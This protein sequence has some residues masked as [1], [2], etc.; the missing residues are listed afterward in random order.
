MTEIQIKKLE[1]SEVEII[2]ELPEKDFAVYRKG[3]LEKI[4]KNIDVPG[5]RKGH[6]PENILIKR[7]PERAI[8]EEMAEQA[9]AKIYPRIL[10]DHQIDA[11]GRPEITIIKLA[12]DNPLGFKIKTAVMPEVRLPDYKTIAKKEA[13]PKENVSV[14]DEEVEKA[15]LEIQK[16]RVASATKE[17]KNERTKTPAGTEQLPRESASSPREPALPKVDD[18][19]VKS[20]GNFSSAEDFKTKLKENIKL[21]K[22]A[23]AREKRRVKII[24]GIVQKTTI[25]L[26]RV[27]I[28]TELDKMLNQLRSDISTSDFTFDDYLKHIRKTEANLRGAWEKEAEKRAKIRLIVNQI[29]LRENITP[30]EN[31]IQNELAYILEKHKG[32]DQERTREYVEHVLT[33]EK[34]FQFLEKQGE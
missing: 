14:T 5:F 10:I 23:K 33:N 17:R 7:I 20:L 8:L 18:E 12:K 29:S 24:E 2:G 11:I 16:M 26:P 6:V 1:K 21:E 4:G 15:I 19:F 25:D 31:D 30:D 28:E 13:G 32:A 9:L 22:E 3:A 34:V 27:L